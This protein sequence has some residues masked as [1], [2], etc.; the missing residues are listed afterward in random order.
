MRFPVWL[1]P[2]VTELA[3]RA[4]LDVVR[5]HPQVHV[6]ARRMRLL[7][8]RGIDLIF[9]VGANVGQYASE[10]RRHGYRGRIVSFEPQ[11]AAFGELERRRARDPRW[12]TVQTGVG[13]CAGVATLHIAANSQSSSLLPMLNAHIESAPG[14]AFVRDEQI[15]I[16]TLEN[17]IRR[18]AQAEERLFVKIDAQGYEHRIVHS[19]GALIDRALGF[20]LEMSLTPLYEGERLLADLLKDLDAMGYDL[21][22]IEPGHSEPSSGRLLQADGIFLRRS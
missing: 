17:L 18:H 19:A 6:L 10:L 20:Q 13:D 12:T 3:R 15:A 9:D 22:S 4:G 14:S 7:E 16:E 11:A 21:V 2:L 8:A 1:P 5:Y